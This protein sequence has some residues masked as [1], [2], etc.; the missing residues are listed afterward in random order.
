MWPEAKHLMGPLGQQS[1]RSNG[2]LDTKGRE[3]GLD[4]AENPEHQEGF[5]GHAKSGLKLQSPSDL[6][7]SHL[8]HSCRGNPEAGRLAGKG[9]HSSPQ[10]NRKAAIEKRGALDLRG[11]MKAEQTEVKQAHSWLACQEG[12]LYLTLALWKLFSRRETE[13]SIWGDI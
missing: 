13:E 1:Q 6:W 3:S 11:C 10:E 2:S 9:L 4:A 12:I 8:S 5:R 7:S